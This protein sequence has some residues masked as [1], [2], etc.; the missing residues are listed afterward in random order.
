MSGVSV[1]RS[2]HVA[3]VAVLVGSLLGACTQARQEVALRAPVQPRGY[4]CDLATATVVTFGQ[5]NA[6]LYADLAL[7]QQVSELR[8]YM[9]NAGLRRIRVVQQTNS[10]N[11]WKAPFPYRLVECTARAQMCGR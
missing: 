8:G 9:F 5:A 6:K 11:G 2:L 1:V 4:A 7:K 3:L 10:C